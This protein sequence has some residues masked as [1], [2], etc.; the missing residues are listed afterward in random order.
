MRVDPCAGVVARNVDGFV[1]LV[2]RHDDGMWALPGGHLEPGESWEQCARREFTEET[3]MIVHLT[4]LL[5]VYSD[6][7]TQRHLTHDGHEIHFVGVVFEGE[8]DGEPQRDADDEIR[9]VRYFA[10]TELPSAVFGPD[11]PVLEDAVSD[12]PRPIIR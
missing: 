10:P 7:L 4:G 1:L 3:G 9:E 5:G 6:P 2:Q 8:V 12:T 11:R